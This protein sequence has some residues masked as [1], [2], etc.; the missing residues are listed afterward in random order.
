[1]NSGA[2][3]TKVIKRDNSIVD[4][5]KSKISKAIYKAF[6]SQGIDDYSKSDS[7]ADEV[8]EILKQKIKNGEISIP[9]VEQIQDI[10][11][12][13]L[14][15]SGYYEVAKHYISYRK[16]K[17][18]IRKE[19]IAILG[20]YYDEKIAK[21]FSVNAIR[22][23]ANRYL[24]KDENGELIEGPKQLF[25]RVALLVVIP[26]ILHDERIFDVNAKQNIF[27][28]PKLDKDYFY[29]LETQ[30]LGF[31]GVYFNIFITDIFMIK[32]LSILHIMNLQYLQ[33][34]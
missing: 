31:I 9:N 8:V 14:L 5:D 34:D 23:M 24:L 20:S 6:L 22:L 16:E 29:N 26:D 27:D 19:K 12:Y 4:F 32:L 7:L 30:K 13:V 33:Q 18:K 25:E 28:L 3:L 2:I 10:V 17:D 1:M 21:R 15:R 11:E